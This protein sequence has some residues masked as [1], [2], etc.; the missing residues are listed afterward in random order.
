MGG[1]RVSNAEAREIAE[2]LRQQF[3]GL[4]EQW[5][6][7]GSVRRGKEIC[8][9]VDLVVVPKDGFNDVLGGLFGWQVP[10]RKADPPKAK[11]TGLVDGV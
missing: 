8:G 1:R 9:D 2:R 11:K 3:D 4:Y 5:E 7:A 6:I 10:K